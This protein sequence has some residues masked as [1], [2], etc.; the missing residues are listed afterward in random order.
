MKK[1]CNKINYTSTI[2]RG[3]RV[4]HFTGHLFPAPDTA[5][6]NI[7]HRNHVIESLNVRPSVASNRRVPG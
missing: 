6:D 2:R 1:K 5:L 3:Q 4:P 7:L